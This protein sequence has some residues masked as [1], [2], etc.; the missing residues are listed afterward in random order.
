M[1]SFRIFLLY[2][3]YNLVTPTRFERVTYSLE[4]CCSIQLSYRAEKFY[5][6]LNKPAT[7]KNVCK[8]SSN[9]GGSKNRMED[10]CEKWLFSIDKPELARV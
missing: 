3:K 2:L 7:F 5:K 9:C 6:S 4:G 8:Y 1:R 10:F